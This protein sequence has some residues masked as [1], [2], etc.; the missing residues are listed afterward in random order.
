MKLL[1]HIWFFATLWTVAH[2][3]PPS[4]GLKGKINKLAAI[5]FYMQNPLIFLRLLK[6]A[7]LK[8]LIGKDPDAGNDWGHEEKGATNNGIIEWHH[9]LSGHDCEK[10]LGESE[11]QGSQACCSLCD[12][13]EA[14]MT[15]WLTNFAL[16]EKHWFL[17]LCF[18]ISA[19][20]QPSNMFP[21]SVSAFNY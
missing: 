3:A 16:R 10:I 17:L 9:R 14:D 1:S 20:F 19:Y 13:N 8:I 18:E 7:S 21:I 12:C 5:Q 6:I 15:E 4:I 2:Q 11:G